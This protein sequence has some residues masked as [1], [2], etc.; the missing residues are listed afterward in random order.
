MANLTACPLLSSS[1]CHHVDPPIWAKMR[2]VVVYSRSVRSVRAGLVQV[3]KRSYPSI[4]KA[5]SFSHGRYLIQWYTLILVSIRSP[6]NALYTIAPTTPE[7]H[8]YF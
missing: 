6:D 8:I 3:G 5:T 7:R 1:L 4:L 2:A